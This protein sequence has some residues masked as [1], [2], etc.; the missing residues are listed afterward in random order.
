M[1]L[2]IFPLQVPEIA[3]KFVRWLR[4]LMSRKTENM[5]VNVNDT[6]CL[7]LGVHNPMRHEI[8]NRTELSEIATCITKEDPRFETNPTVGFG[9]S[10]NHTSNTLSSQNEEHL[11]NK[12]NS[13]GN[14]RPISS[15]KEKRKWRTRL[16]TS[17]LRQRASPPLTATEKPKYHQNS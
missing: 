8:S 16:Y 10:Y 13:N 7:P 2:N 6:A 9:N 1:H 11:L 4:K 17:R 14:L 3:D 12:K 15:M 5:L